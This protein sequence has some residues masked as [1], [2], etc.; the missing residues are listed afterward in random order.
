MTD[1]RTGSLVFVFIC[2]DQ[3]SYKQVECFEECVSG[4]EKNNLCLKTEVL[5]VGKL[6]NGEFSEKE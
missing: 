2:K 6:N 5:T 3:T 4:H 1:Y